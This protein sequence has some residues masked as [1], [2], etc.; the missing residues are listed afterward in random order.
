MKK[1]F[2]VLLGLALPLVGFSQIKTEQ[3]F[4]SGG[5][6]VTVVGNNLQGTIGEAIMFE[7]SPAKFTQGFNQPFVV[8]V[9]NISAELLDETD[10]LLCV[11]EIFKAELKNDYSALTAV[12][13]EWF[14]KPIGGTSIGSGQSYDY[15]SAS[16]TTDDLYAI[17]KEGVCEEQSSFVAVDVVGS[18]TV[19]STGTDLCSGAVELSI[20]VASSEINWFLDGDKIEGAKGNQTYKVLVG[21]KYT[22]VLDNSSCGTGIQPIIVSS[23]PK[24]TVNNVL[25]SLNASTTGSPDTHQWYIEIAGRTYG[26]VG[27]T[28]ASYIPRYKGKYKVEVTK[29][30]CQTV[31]AWQTYNSATY[32]AK[33]FAKYIEGNQV[34][35]EEV[36]ELLTLSPNPNN[37]EFSLN[38]FGAN[39]QRMQV[40]LYNALGTQVFANNYATTGEIPIQL[41]LP[42]GLYLVVVEVAGELYKEKLIIK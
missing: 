21:G 38:Y 10:Q 2:I 42:S 5:G 9:C 22:A 7:A 12:T 31:S 4:A 27:A 26:I 41:D 8:P 35:L 24:V 40:K 36:T 17:I 32:S 30:S 37:G 16:V 11:S 18:P 15:S 13:I 6:N 1:L 3:V 25:N 14:K 20:S 39:N 29:A 19:S 28:N 23:F 34:V 33:R